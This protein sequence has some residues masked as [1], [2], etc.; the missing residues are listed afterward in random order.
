MFV[1]DRREQLFV[2]VKGWGG[3]ADGGKEHQKLAEK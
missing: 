3:Y 2:T 1:T